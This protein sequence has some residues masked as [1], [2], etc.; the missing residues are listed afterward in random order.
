M[1]VVRSITGEAGCFS[2]IL[3]SSPI[4][5]NWFVPLPCYYPL[6]TLAAYK[7]QRRV[8]YHDYDYDHAF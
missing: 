8:G 7:E 5:A 4:S 2:V 6:E 3:L 1:V